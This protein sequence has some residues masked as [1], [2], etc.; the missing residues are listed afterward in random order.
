MYF[1][2]L[3]ALFPKKDRDTINHVFISKVLEP[4][5][6]DDVTYMSLAGSFDAQLSPDLEAVAA[7]K[8]I[9]YLSEQSECKRSSEARLAIE[10]SKL[11]LD[12]TKSSTRSTG[13]LETEEESGKCFYQVLV[14]WKRYEGFWNTEF[15]N[16]LFNRVEKLTEFLKASSGSSEILNL[17]LLDCLGYCHDDLKQRLGFVYAFPKSAGSQRYYLRLNGLL[18]E[19]TDGNLNPPPVGDRMR[20]AKILCQAM[21]GFHR[22]QWFHK[23]FSSYNVLLFPDV[24]ESD[25]RDFNEAH[26]AQDFSILVPYIVGFNNSRPSNP[27]ELSEPGNISTE[28]HHYFHPSYK[29]VPLQKYMHEFDYYSLGIVLLEIGLWTPL[30]ALTSRFEEKDAEKFSSVVQ[31][32]ICPLLSSSVG[33]IYQGIVEILLG[34]FHTVE[35]RAELS[36]PT[37]LGELIELQTHVLE[38]L[39]QCKA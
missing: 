7:M 23:S 8:R 38:Q 22:A 10:F 18:R 17:R 19:Y 16:E 28:A 11:T 30:S 5:Y 1:Q 33:S 34:S 21:F 6:S 12:K 9:K 14:E 31:K 32:N 35:G 24:D 29:N 2:Q 15:G 26:R 13:I 4:D 39:G 37:P 20:L 27:S 25:D 3:T 36:N